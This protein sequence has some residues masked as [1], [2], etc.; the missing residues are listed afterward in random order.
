MRCSCG[1]VFPNRSS[2]K[3]YSKKD[4]LAAA[5]DDHLRKNQLLFG[6]DARFKDYYRRLAKSAAGV[7]AG[8][9]ATPKRSARKKVP[10]QTDEEVT[11]S[12]PA[13][14]RKAPKTETDGEDEAA[15]HDATSDEAET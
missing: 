2:R 11:P 15:S 1:P 4:A 9:G 10:V 14:R 3:Q 6:N 7:G 13:A 5:L 12:P 8:A